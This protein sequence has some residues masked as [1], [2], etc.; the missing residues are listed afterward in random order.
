MLLRRDHSARR[1][2]KDVGCSQLALSKIWNKYKQKGKIQFNQERRQSVW[3]EGSK[4][5]P[6]KTG[7]EQQRK[8]QNK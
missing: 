8:W 1:D 7:N 2:A 6:L 4:Q 3:T 5:Y